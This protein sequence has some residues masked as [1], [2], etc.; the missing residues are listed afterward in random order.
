MGRIS[1]GFPHYPNESAVFLWKNNRKSVERT[2]KK[3]ENS[4]G[5]R[6]KDLFVNVSR[7][8]FLW[9]TSQK[10]WIN[11]SHLWKIRPKNPGRLKNT[12]GKPDSV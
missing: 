7:I 10:L 11:H 9:I 1:P 6:T 8:D 2:S 3:V 5:A 12:A 4:K